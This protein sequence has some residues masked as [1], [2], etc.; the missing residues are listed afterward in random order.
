MKNPDFIFIS[1][2]AL[3]G[4]RPISKICRYG[5][6]PVYTGVSTYGTSGHAD[7]DSGSVASRIGTYQ[8]FVLR[9][10]QF[11]FIIIMGIRLIFFLNINNVILILIL[12]T[13]S[14]LPIGS[15]KLSLFL[16]CL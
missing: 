16:T 1:R 5:T 12:C 11:C 6:I 7:E 2:F 14:V 8:N 3:S 4:T 9:V 10:N 15:S 13:L